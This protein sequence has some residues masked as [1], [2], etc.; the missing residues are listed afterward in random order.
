MHGMFSIHPRRLDCKKRVNIVFLP[1]RQHLHRIIR[2][3]R[4]QMVVTPRQMW[5]AHD[6]QPADIAVRGDVAHLAQ[7]SG[8]QEAL[9]LHF[10]VTHAQAGRGGVGQAGG[11]TH[12]HEVRSGVRVRANPSAQGPWDGALSWGWNELEEEIF[13]VAFVH[14]D[15]KLACFG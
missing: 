15:T 2:F 7:A 12:H 3:H 1:S 8:T 13:K 6:H 5:G 9:A 4:E 11:E 10:R 14:G